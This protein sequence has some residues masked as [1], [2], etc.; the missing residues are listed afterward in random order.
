M[1]KSRTRVTFTIYF[2]KSGV[3]IPARL[4]CVFVLTSE[5]FGDEKLCYE[6]NPEQFR[7]THWQKQEKHE[8]YNYLKAELLKKLE[9]L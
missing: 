7:E 1:K 8:R 9:E 6:N 5:Q 2:R 4:A 3:N